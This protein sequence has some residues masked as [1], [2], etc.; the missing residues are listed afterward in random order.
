M[1]ARTQIVVFGAGLL[2]VFAALAFVTVHLLELEER[3]REQTREARVRDTVRL[4]LW[5]MDAMLTS[6]VAREAARP[7]FEYQPFYAPSEAGLTVENGSGGSNGAAVVPSP[8]LVNAAPYVKL[9]FQFPGEEV[10]LLESPQVPWGIARQ[11]AESAFV[12]AYALEAN[13][14]Q[15][16]RLRRL[17]GG[18]TGGEGAVESFDKRKRAGAYG[19]SRGFGTVQPGG[20][21]GTGGLSSEKLSGVPPVSSGRLEAESALESKIQA[22]EPVVG[23]PLAGVADTA[24]TKGGKELQKQEGVSGEADGG[25]IARREYAQN[26][27]SQET[28]QRQRQ[29]ASNIGDSKADA[30]RSAARPMERADAGGLSDPNST[31]SPA[32]E[33]PDLK[34][35]SAP[36]AIPGGVPS[37]EIG[38]TA[39]AKPGAV[40]RGTTGSVEASAK[41]ESGA[42][43]SRFASTSADQDGERDE[44]TPGR[45]TTIRDGLLPDGAWEAQTFRPRWLVAVGE[46]EPALIFTRLA[47][48]QG[49]SVTQGFWVDW[50]QL[51]AD[52]LKTASDVLPGAELRPMPEAVGDPKRLPP[53]QLSRMLAVIPAELVVPRENADAGPSWSPIRTT[54][55]VAWFSAVLASVALVFV[56]RESVTLAERRGRFVSA[57]TH[58]LRTPLT[59]FCM[60]S[61]ML[62]DDMVPDEAARKSYQNTLKAESQRLA[63]IV[64]SVLDYARLGPDSRSA[65][66]SQ[67]VETTIG[68][69]IAPMVRTLQPRCEGVGKR[70]VVDCRADLDEPVVVDQAIVERIVTNLVENACKYAIPASD[71]RVIVSVGVEVVAGRRGLRI[72]VRDFGPGIPESEREEVFRPFERGRS[73]EHGGVPGL[74]LGLALSRSL[75]EQLS[76]SLTL[77]QPA[78]T[79]VEGDAKGS[80]GAEFLLRVPVHTRKL[81]STK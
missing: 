13:E 9:N 27:I 44:H 22:S 58:E 73:H 26:V 34:E 67:A 62:A 64:E 43:R 8:L 19:D 11:N 59:T 72:A 39:A 41:D 53:E 18:G 77:V 6:V 61:Q 10:E 30:E 23:V 21:T 49:R 74:G 75:A 65:P 28:Q 16:N 79:D 37:E 66:R 56:M 31:G 33:R 17:I 55:S 4:V 51:R 1:K 78:E 20:A 69:L 32:A 15:L 36:M 60:Y 76:G 7:A 57:V 24:A 29:I 40:E 46:A 80:G 38:P 35:P 3:E 45:A 68:A 81:D 47:T 48:V 54:L 71:D 52:L 5:R 25:Y 2:A 42:L 14:G 63:G 70:L 50:S 12:T